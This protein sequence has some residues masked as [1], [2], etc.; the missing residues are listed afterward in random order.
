MKNSTLKKS[1]R[2]CAARKYLIPPFRV[3]ADFFPLR[4][5]A[6][7]DIAG[8][9]RDEHA[10]ILVANHS[11]AVGGNGAGHHPDTPLQDKTQI[12]RIMFGRDARRRNSKPCGDRSERAH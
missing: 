1:S 11:F 7:R 9:R 4:N 6:I 8:P 12:L 5:R 2:K 10:R 3:D